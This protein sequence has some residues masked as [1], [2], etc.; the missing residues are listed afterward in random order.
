MALLIHINVP[1][2]LNR[3][4]SPRLF[5]PGAF[6][7]QNAPW[8]RGGLPSLLSRYSILSVDDLTRWLAGTRPF[9]NRAIR[10]FHAPEIFSK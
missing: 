2:A 7:G 10:Y 5:R 3:A 8:V 9:D 1:K 6:F 4:L